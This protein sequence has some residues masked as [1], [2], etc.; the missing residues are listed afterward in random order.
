MIPRPALRDWNA[1]GTDELLG[2]IE[3]IAESGAKQRPDG[4]RP[5]SPTAFLK[6][7]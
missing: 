1:E 7:R 2:M 4:V 6:C 3:V 5:F